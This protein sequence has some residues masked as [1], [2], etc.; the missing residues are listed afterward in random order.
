MASFNIYNSIKNLKVYFIS[1]LGA[2]ERVF[3]HIKLPPGHD[4]VHLKWIKPGENE[5]LKSYALRLAENIDSSEK[6]SLVGLSLG[7][8]IATEIANRVIPAHTILI[9]SIPTSSDLPGYYKLAGKLGLHRI[10]PVGLVKRAAKFKRLFTT[11]TAEDK[12]M[13]RSMIVD[14]DD[15]FVKWAL[16]AVLTWDNKIT[17]QNLIHLHG[18][19]DE[20]LPK[21]YTTPTYTLR[22]AGHLMVMNRAKEIND[23]LDS[24]FKPD[25]GFGQ[26]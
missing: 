15:A 13:L 3:K 17:P 26:V 12:I 11:E 4:I 25:H 14:A 7:G 23:I 8:M 5:S 6:F 18:S 1:G 21:R 20:V 24:V 16:N 22:G 2:D 10:A 9:S 19:S